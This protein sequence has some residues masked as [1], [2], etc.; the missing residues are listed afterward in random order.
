[1]S[2]TAK[3]AVNVK[4]VGSMGPFPF[5]FGFVDYFTEIFKLIN[6]NIGF[7]PMVYKME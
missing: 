3:T 7:N 2:K 6:F 1:M 5:L 4:L